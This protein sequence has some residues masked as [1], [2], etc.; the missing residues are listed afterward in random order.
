MT[1]ALPDVDLVLPKLA[2]IEAS[3]TGIVRAYDTLPNSVPELPC[4]VNFVG[5]MTEDWNNAGEDE[6]TVEG[7]ETATYYP[8][9]IV[10]P[11]AAGYTGEPQNRCYP[12]I[13]KVRNKFASLPNLQGQNTWRMI[14]QGHDGVRIV[15]VAGTDYIGVRFTILVSGYVQVTLAE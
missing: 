9:L 8:T 3:I 5:P 2:Q 10:A 12:F 4:F 15:Q 6:T 13:A 11:A 14:F 7:V 1:V